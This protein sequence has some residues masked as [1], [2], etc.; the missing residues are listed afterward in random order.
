LNFIAEQYNI[1]AKLGT[2]F[3]SHRTILGWHPSQRS[4]VILRTNRHTDTHG[5]WP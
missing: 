5:D 4:R 1:N 2:F 3:M